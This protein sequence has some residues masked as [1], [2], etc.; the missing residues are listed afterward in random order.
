VISNTDLELSQLQTDLQ[1]VATHIRAS[2]QSRQGDTL[3]LLALLRMLESLHREIRDSVFQESLP[4]NRQALYNLLKDIE[5]EGGWPYIQRMKLRSLLTN[6]QA[7]VSEQ[8]LAEV[9]SPPTSSEAEA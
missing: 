1:T 4:D 9:V 5:T 6:L 2:A 7:E 8:T 3:A